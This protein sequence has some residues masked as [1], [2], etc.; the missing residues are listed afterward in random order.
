MLGGMKAPFHLPAAGEAA[1][2]LGVEKMIDFSDVKV[3]SRHSNPTEEAY[4]GT[5]SALT[6]QIF[7][8]LTD[9]TRSFVK[10]A[11]APESCLSDH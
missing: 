2:K 11:I 9:V 4:P 1:K 7:R 10:T 8:Y 5:G 6:V 3:W